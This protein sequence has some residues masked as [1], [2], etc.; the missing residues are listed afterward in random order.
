MYAEQYIWNNL[1]TNHEVHRIVVSIVEHGDYKGNRRVLCGK[2]I[3]K[4]D[5]VL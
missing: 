4:L 3:I 1:Y 2:A 5:T